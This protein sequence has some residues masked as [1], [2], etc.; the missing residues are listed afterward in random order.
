MLLP[1]LAVYLPA[2]SSHGE[3]AAARVFV[4]ELCE[5]GLSLA[6][7]AV[8]E[9]ILDARDCCLEARAEARAIR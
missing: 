9:M 1:Y 2:K 3:H 8:T 5:S 4:L 7:T 6:Q